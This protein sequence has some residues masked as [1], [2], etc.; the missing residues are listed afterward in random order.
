MIEPARAAVLS[1]ARRKQVNDRLA[2][3]ATTACL[4]LAVCLTGLFSALAAAPRPA[5]AGG[6]TLTLQPGGGDAALTKALSDYR[7]AAERAS[8][9]AANSTPT[10][11]LAPPRH[12][13][14]AAA[15]HPAAVSGGS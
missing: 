12:A 6:V 4:S 2:R 8:S 10:K 3:R 13:P 9:T 7:A 14:V 11:A 15:S 1:P 5:S